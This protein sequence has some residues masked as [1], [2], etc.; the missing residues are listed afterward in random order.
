[1]SIKIPIK[2][3]WWTQNV[4]LGRGKF[5][6]SAT[7]SKDLALWFLGHGV[8]AEQPGQPDRLVPLSNVLT[9]ES[10]ESLTPEEWGGGI[11]Q[12][13]SGL[14]SVAAMEAR[15]EVP[16]GSTLQDIANRFPP[17]KDPT[18]GEHTHV[19][20]PAP[21][22]VAEGERRLALADSLVPKKRGPGKAGT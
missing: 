16:A 8:L 13:V 14:D 19:I 12:R 6:K 7:A 22:V 10:S 15:G 21:E 20:G 17:A 5:G 2:T 18:A 9:M 1:V 4:D 3:A 11:A